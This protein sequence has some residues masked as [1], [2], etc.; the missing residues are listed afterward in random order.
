LI[1]RIGAAIA[2]IENLLPSR[3]RDKSIPLNFFAFLLTGLLCNAHMTAPEEWTPW[4]SASGSARLA[5]KIKE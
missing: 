4:K 3:Y 5:G 2:S 1:K